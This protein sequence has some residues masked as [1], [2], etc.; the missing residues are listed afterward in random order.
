MESS[1]AEA[2]STDFKKESRIAL[3][4]MWKKK[5]KKKHLFAWLHPIFPIA[6]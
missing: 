2:L 3:S 1:E 4:T 5:R 6:S